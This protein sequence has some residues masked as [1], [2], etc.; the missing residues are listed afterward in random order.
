MGALRIVGVI[1]YYQT[2]VV[3]GKCYTNMPFLYYHGECAENVDIG[4]DIDI[5]V[6]VHKKMRMRTL[7]LVLGEC[8]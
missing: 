6:M 4:E 1:D 7:C 5:G 3:Y 2:L 8:K